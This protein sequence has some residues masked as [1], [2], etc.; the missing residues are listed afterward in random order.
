MFEK[1][2]TSDPVNNK[3]GATQSEVGLLLRQA[4]ASTTGES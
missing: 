3:N 4:T 1:D 2:A